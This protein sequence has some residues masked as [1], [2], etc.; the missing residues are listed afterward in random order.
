VASVVA[1]TTF[2]W[3]LAHAP[4]SLVST[5]AYVNPVVAVVLGWVWLSEPITWPVVVGGVVV[6]VAVALVM[7]ERRRQADEPPL[8]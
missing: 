4:I 6:L 2:V 1:Y 7:T 3:L 8:S 5:H